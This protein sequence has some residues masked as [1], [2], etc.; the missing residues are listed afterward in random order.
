M[1]AKFIGEDKSMGFRNGKEYQIETYVAG[2][3]K[4]SF[5]FVR[6]VG[7]KV[8]CPYRNMEKILENWEIM[9]VL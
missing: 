3:R 6:V 4:V 2:S 1:I 9:G 8:S 7:T 5:I